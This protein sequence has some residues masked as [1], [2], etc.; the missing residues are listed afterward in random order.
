MANGQFTYSE[1]LSQPDVWREVLDII[2]KSEPEISRQWQAVSPKQVL[3]TGCGSTYYLSLTAAALLQ[4][5]TGIPCRGVP[6]SEIV[7]FP[8]NTVA[9]PAETLLIAVSRSGTTTETCAAL[10]RFKQLGGKAIW[11][12]TN[13]PGTPVDGESDFSIVLPQAQEQSVAQTRTFSSMLLATQAIAAIAGGEDIAPLFDLPQHA[14]D[15]LEQYE[16]LSERLGRSQDLGKSFFLGSGPL[17]GIACEVMLKMKEMSISYSEAYHFMEYRHGPKSMVDEHA[18]IVGLLSE[19]VSSFEEPVLEECANMGGYTLAFSQGSTVE[20]FRE[21][22][23]LPG[24]LPWWASP[25]LYLPVL[26]LIAYYR[27]V[28]K[29]LDPDNPRNLTAVVELDHDELVGATG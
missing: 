20:T 4:G 23:V 28:S 22:V 26:Q 12:V 16:P 19:R 21:T 17:Y 5:M 27:S 14:G 11:G 8:E 6:A 29:G 15:L 24:G 7:L 10:T 18:L 13:Y 9:N 25:A 1:I 3:F 2:R